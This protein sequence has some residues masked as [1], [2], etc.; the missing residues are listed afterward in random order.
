MVHII[1]KIFHAPNSN[2]SIFI[3]DLCSKL[4]ALKFDRCRIFIIYVY[5]CIHLF[6]YCELY[7]FCL[8]RHD[9]HKYEHVIVII[10]FVCWRQFLKGTPFLQS[11]PSVLC[12]STVPEEPQLRVLVQDATPRGLTVLWGPSTPPTSSTAVNTTASTSTI[13]SQQAATQSPPMQVCVARDS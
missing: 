5:K 8:F 7:Y 3:S 4:I 9:V 2:D 12:P 6:A 13:G 11:P 10:V 1:S